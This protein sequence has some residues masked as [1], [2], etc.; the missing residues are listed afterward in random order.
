MQKVKVLL[1][2]A[3]MMALTA[4]CGAMFKGTSQEITV[5]SN[6]PGATVTIT[7]TGQTLTTPGSITLAKKNEYTLKFEM[8][9]YKTKEVFI[10]QDMNGTRLNLFLLVP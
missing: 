10:R 7:P 9:G 2:I 5:K 6:P 4:G 8:P 1:V 3:L